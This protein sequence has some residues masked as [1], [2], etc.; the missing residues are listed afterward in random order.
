MVDRLSE[1][2][3]GYLKS[4]AT[5]S[6]QLIERQHAIGQRIVTKSNQLPDLRV[7][8]DTFQRQRFFMRSNDN[9]STA[10]IGNKLHLGGREHD[11]D[12]LITAPVLSAP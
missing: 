3:F 2:N 6:Q 5:R 4:V 12:G 1:V 10:I 11:I 8:F 9:R 7:F